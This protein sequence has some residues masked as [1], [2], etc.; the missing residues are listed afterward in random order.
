M[1]YKFH[2]FISLILSC[3]LFLG[4][5]HSVNEDQ[6]IQ[7][8][9]DTDN[10]L[11]KTSNIGNI[12]TEIKYRP[13]DQMVW[14]ELRNNEKISDSLLEAKRKLYN[15][16]Y[17]FIMNISEGEKDFLHG[18]SNSFGQFS[19]NLTKLSFRMQEFTWMKADNDTIYLA[20][21]QFP[22]LYGMIGTTQVLLAFER[23]EK[24]VEKLEIVLDDFGI[25][26]GKQNFK[27]ETNSMKEIPALIF[28]KN[29][30]S[31]FNKEYK[32]N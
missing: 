29:E 11:V 3:F 26:V 13:T 17:Y 6:L 28:K 18:G 32:N 15:K 21:F 4:C 19:D 24:E 2:C 7:Y 23:P 25:G 10:G 16:Y 14:Q 30:L 1:T 12:K 31:Y 5:K 22:R 8:I 9:A 20:D 27:F